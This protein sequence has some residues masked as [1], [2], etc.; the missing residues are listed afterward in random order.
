MINACSNCKHAR[1]LKGTS[2]FECRF[3]PPVVSDAV[4]AHYIQRKIPVLTIIK[5]ATTYPVT[6]KD[7]WCGKWE[8]STRINRAPCHSNAAA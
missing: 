2:S 6:H 7:E 1:K 5:D 3:N 4:V 8:Q